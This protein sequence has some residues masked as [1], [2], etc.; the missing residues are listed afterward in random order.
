M[1]PAGASLMTSHGRPVRLYVPC[2]QSPSH[3][4]S[5]T[6][7]RSRHLALFRHETPPT[8]A[9]SFF[10]CVFLEFSVKSCGT[11]ASRDPSSET[12][13]PPPPPPPP[14]LRP[15]ACARR[16]SSPAAFFDTHAVA[17]SSSS[18][19]SASPAPLFILIVTLFLGFFF[20]S[21]ADSTIS[22]L[23]DPR[24]DPQ[25]CPHAHFRHRGGACLRP[26]RGRLPSTGAASTSSLAQTLRGHSEG[27]AW[28]A[29]GLAPSCA[30]PS[31]ACTF[32]SS[33][34][35]CSRRPHSKGTRRWRRRPQRGSLE[36]GPSRPRL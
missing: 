36:R 30:H 33:A 7:S 12:P 29:A 28:L 27:A 23:R 4:P 15:V 9:F 13:S 8:R 20:S 31:G 5:R 32:V 10:F 17:P 16:S 19:S 25:A 11:I 2:T 18:A 3:M 14:T 24:R 1:L 26:P 34:Q 6:A 21:L 22:F 35:L